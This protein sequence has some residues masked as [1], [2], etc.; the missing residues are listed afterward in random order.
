MDAIAQDHR[1]QALWTDLTDRLADQIERRQAHPAR[2]V[3]LLPYAQLMPL[4]RQ[5]W[6]RRVPSGFAPRFETTMNWAGAGDFEPG[7]Q[8][9]AFD[10]ARD[11]LVAR[12]LLAQAGFG[13]RAD[14]LAGRLVEAASQLAPLAAAA[15]P[16]QRGAWAARARAAVGLGLD[17]PVLQIEAALA[18]IAVEWVAASGYATDSL[19]SDTTMQSLDLLVVME[20]LQ[21]ELLLQ[22]LVERMGDK[23]AR[24]PLTTAAPPGNIAL[25]PAADR[26][27]EAQRAAACVLR[28]VEAGRVPVALAAT[29]RVL[30][31]CIA[32]LLKQAGATTR[33]EPGWKLSTTRSAAHVMV[34]LKG[35]A[36]DA[37]SDAVL[38]WLK[39]APACAAGAVLG[40]ER[41]LRQ[42]GLREWR[43]LREA[44][45]GESTALCG[46]L[47]QVNGWREAMAAP[48]QLAQWLQSLRAALHASGQWVR[49]ARDDAGAR[50]LDVLRLAEGSEAEFEP[51][52]R[53]GRRLALHEFTAWVDEVLEAAKFVPER[54]G[55]APV[56][57]LPFE[58]TLGRPFAAVVLPGCDEQRLPASPEPSGPWTAAQRRALGLPTRE[59]LEAVQR[60]AWQQALQAPHC[61]L[62]WRS[63][64]DQGEPLLPS[65]LLLALKLQG[66]ARPAAD[67]REPRMLEA[68]PVSRP[69]PSAGALLPLQLSASAYEDL[70]RC[71]YRFFALRQLGLKEADEVDTEVGKRDF[72]TWLHAVLRRFEMAL[73]DEGEPADGRAALLDR[74]AEKERGAL[75]LQEGEFLPFEAAWPAV[76]DGYLRWQSQHEASGARFAQAESEHETDLGPL[77]LAGRIDRID[78]SRASQWLV[79]DYK[80]EALQASKDRMKQFLEDTQLAFY[81][82]L[83]QPQPLRAAYLNIGERGEVVAVEHPDVLGARE[84]MRGAITAEWQRIGEGAP[85]PALGEGKV[86]DFCA[87][88][89]LC[90][91]DFW[92]G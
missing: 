36:W 1:V 26:A 40:L 91:K 57:I 25:H 62:L 23:A 27:D 9:F 30:T 54:G 43:W 58:Q 17:A 48:R 5:Y 21:S 35:C 70:R 24:L 14:A 28:H 52:A 74:I 64:D 11:L 67:P 84:L 6:S 41:R 76:R 69:T 18:R 12:E 66:T 61:D 39:H 7:A 4:A 83:L 90:R 13:A 60:A 78:T 15:L 45:C 79:I 20:G 33:D 49:L 38:D 71:P 51:L 53:A 86:C 80:T 85:L 19:L 75:R 65:P 59:A 8:D 37:A 68:R 77:K 3:V 63:S 44:D 73:K 32:A 46:L 47:A 89:G 87:A 81:G 72:G 82:L 2:T 42:T 50:V 92:H 10:V 55:D 16:V 29:D 34:L 88:R 22:A 56:V 31:R